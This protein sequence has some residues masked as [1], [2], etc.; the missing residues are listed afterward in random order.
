V[1][2][3]NHTFKHAVQAIHQV[4]MAMS[5]VPKRGS[6]RTPQ[7]INKPLKHGPLTSVVLSVGHP[8]EAVRFNREIELMACGS[9]A[10]SYFQVSVES[11]ELN[12]ERA[13]QFIINFAQKT[14]AKFKVAATRVVELVEDQVK[15]SSDVLILG[16]QKLLEQACR[17]ILE[18]NEPTFAERSARAWSPDTKR[19]IEEQKRLAPQKEKERQ[20]RIHKA[21]EYA[22]KLDKKTKIYKAGYCKK[23]DKTGCMCPRPINPNDLATHPLHSC[24][25]GKHVRLKPI[26]GPQ[27]HEMGLSMS[28]EWSYCLDCFEVIDYNGVARGFKLSTL[29][30]P[31]DS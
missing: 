8:L 9:H 6:D 1:K 2:V 29:D 23:C 4:A 17:E 14:A 21:Q 18:P 26:P 31:Q 16:E 15:R 25:G 3:T 7:D 30:A 13:K 28:Q 19:F 24:K 5:F 10:K 27:K 12:L 22:R 20:E 11:V